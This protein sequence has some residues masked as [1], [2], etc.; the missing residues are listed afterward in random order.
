M[1]D[2]L[3]QLAGEGYLNLEENRGAYVASMSYKSLR[4]F[5][6]TAPPIYSSIAGLAVENWKPAQL[7]ALKDAQAGFRAA[8]ETGDANQMAFLN[9][10]F[11]L[12]MGKMADNRYL[13]PSL[14]RLLI[15]HARIGQTFYRP[16]DDTMRERLATACL[17]HDQFIDAIEAGDVEAAEQLAHD[18]WALSRDN[19]EMYVRPMPLDI[20]VRGAKQQNI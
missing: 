3:R 8:V 12:I 6:R 13:Q 7:Q 15:D 10:Q 2:V 9:N 1:R 20:E 11:H 4:D 19:I 18:H 14:M 5:F 16:R 17:Q